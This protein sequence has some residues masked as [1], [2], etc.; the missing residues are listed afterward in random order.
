MNWGGAMSGIEGAKVTGIYW[1]IRKLVREHGFV[2][3]LNGSAGRNEQP[4]FQA[5]RGRSVRLKMVNR[6]PWPHA[7][8][9]HGHHFQ[10]IQRTDGR[11]IS[12]HWRDTI[13]MDPDSEMQI[14]F[15]ADNPG[16][17]MLHCH[18]LEHMAGGMVTWFEVTE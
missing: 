2:W 9:V 8:H 5:S 18:M 1:P 4:L 3:A 13:L 16:K 11:K 15:V 7:M 14:A 6:T 10:V 12:P 17:W